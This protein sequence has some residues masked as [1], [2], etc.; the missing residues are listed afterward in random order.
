MTW[1]APEHR[2][3]SLTKLVSDRRGW[4][5]TKLQPPDEFGP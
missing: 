4:S 1:L 2:A 5:L 3:W